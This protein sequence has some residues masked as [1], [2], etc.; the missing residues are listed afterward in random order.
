MQLSIIAY[1][2]IHTSKLLVVLVIRVSLIY[3]LTSGQGSAVRLTTSSTGGLSCSMRGKSRH[4]TTLSENLTDKE[5]ATAEV[6]E[7]VVDKVTAQKVLNCQFGGRE[8]QSLATMQR[9]YI[10]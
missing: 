9:M 1:T 6:R 7:K 10:F 2:H 8:I 3:H 5:G 4:S